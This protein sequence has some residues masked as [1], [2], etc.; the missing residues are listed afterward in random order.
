MNVIVLVFLALCV[1][2]G[3]TAGI[4]ATGIVGAIVTSTDTTTLGGSTGVTTFAGFAGACAGVVFAV[5][6]CY[7]FMNMVLAKL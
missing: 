1:A 4:G 7:K 5:V 2:V 3:A 6:V